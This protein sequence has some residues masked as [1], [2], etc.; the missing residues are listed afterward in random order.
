MDCTI[1]ATTGVAFGEYDVSATGA[2]DSAGSVEY[3][4]DDV[5]L[6]DFLTIELSS[7][8]S[9]VFTTRQMFNER[10]P[11]YTLDYNLYIDTTRLLIWGDGTLGTLTS[12]PSKP[13]E[14]T[15][16]SVSIYGRIP[17]GQTDAEAG[18][19]SDTITVTL[20]F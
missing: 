4:C 1:T 19:Y 6:L 16:Q 14:G 2:L 7:G 15:S 18:P 8:G 5:G 9:G 20:Q 17:A 11:S 3:V 13:P 10:N 12:G